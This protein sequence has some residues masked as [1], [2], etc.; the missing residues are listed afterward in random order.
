MKSEKINIPVI[1]IS[2]NSSLTEAVQTVQEGAY[3]FLEKPFSNEKLIL[4]VKKCFEYLELKERIS[5]LSN[6]NNLLLGE[7][8]KIAQLRKDGDIISLG[9]VARDLFHF[10]GLNGSFLSRR[11]NKFK[12]KLANDG[13]QHP[14]DISIAA[15]SL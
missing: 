12:K 1:F 5:V 13:I 3:D 2:G 11:V 6:E 9:V 14:D 15:C 4:T 10:K 7:D 8:K